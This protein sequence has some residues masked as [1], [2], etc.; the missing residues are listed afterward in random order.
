MRARRLGLVAYDFDGVMTNNLV[1]VMDDGREAVQ[2]NRS[3]GL[4]IGI[5]KRA[6]LEQWIVTTERNP[7]VRRRAKK[8]G[9]PVLH[10][11]KDK[12]KAV[13]QLAQQRNV[14][15][16]NVA[17]VGNDLNDLEAMKLCGY[18]LCPADAA[19]PIRDISHYQAKCGGGGGVIREFL[20]V[21]L[22][23]MQK[24]API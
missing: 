2:C 13:R 6:G 7:V 17:F 24:S 21:F 22:K 15:L 1:F 9:I 5:L 3:D 10:T 14:P 16:R 20:P 19:K 4:A 12:A 11:V 23:L 18:R 8:L